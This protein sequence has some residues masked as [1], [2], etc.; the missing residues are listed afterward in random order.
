M[1]SE[2]GAKVINAKNGIVS[3][4][5]EPRDFLYQNNKAFKTTWFVYIRSYII[6]ATIRVL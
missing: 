6:P 2:F 3:I 4:N 5:S 1:V